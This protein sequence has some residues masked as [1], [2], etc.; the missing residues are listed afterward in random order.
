MTETAGDA[1]TLP[2][3]RDPRRPYDP[4]RGLAEL[5]AHSPLTRLRFPDGHLG[6]L[7]TSHELVRAVL[8]DPRF[9]ARYELVHD[10][11]N[12]SGGTLPPAPPGDLSGIDAP[13]HTRLRRAV[14]ARFTVRRMGLLTERIH[15]I[16]AEHLDAMDRT[17]PPLD[18]MSAYAQ[19]VPALTI[20]ELLGVPYDD[21]EF[22]QQ[23]VSTVIEPESFE[24]MGAA[25]QEVAEY[26]ARLAVAK[27]ARPTDDV[28]SEL[29]ATDLTDEEVAGLAT[30][31][32]G[33]GLE[34]TRN[35]IAFGVMVL[36]DHPDQLAAL[37]ADPDLA[38]SAVEELLRY[39]TIAH[40]GARAALEDV[41]L[42][43][44]L[45]RAGETVALSGSAANRDPD[46]FDDPDVLDLR[47]R[48]T[49][50]VAFGHG[51][52]L[53]LGHQLARVELRIALPALLT[54]FPRLALAIEP[55][56]VPLRYGNLLGVRRLPVTW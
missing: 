6:W 55:E 31:L 54:R 13:G 38:D 7:A 42:G 27:R 18:L 17:T 16:C 29:T 52:H 51:A 36:L 3:E 49:G 33:A 24:Q 20:C 56:Q 48:A 1:I 12:D 43:G 19:P 41:E 28:L 34:T 25:W 23:Q 11:V 39:V 46:R 30:F 9:G 4:P 14:A 35:M 53:C 8:A 2:L 32:L 21:H 40:T 10:P 47:R 45:I 50:H 37:R 15:R 44:Q 5:R 22:F 26:L